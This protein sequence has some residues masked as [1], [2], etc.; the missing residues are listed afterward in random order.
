MRQRLN[1]ATIPSIKSGPAPPA[2]SEGKA[3]TPT[4]P[5]PGPRTRPPCWLAHAGTAT[6]S[7]E[8]ACEP[9]GPLSSAID[10]AVANVWVVVGVAPNC[11]VDQVCRSPGT[12]QPTSIRQPALARR[13]APSSGRPLTARKT[14]SAACSVGQRIAQRRSPS[15]GP[16]ASRLRKRAKRSVRSMSPARKMVTSAD[17]RTQKGAQRGGVQDEVCSNSADGSVARKF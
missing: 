12:G 9:C 10:D 16:C 3:A 15:A 13:R 6:A 8:M 2:S 4:P 11:L 7:T 5:P 14:A 17:R 1:Q